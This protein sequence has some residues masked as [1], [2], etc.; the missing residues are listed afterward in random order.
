MVTDKSVTNASK[1]KIIRKHAYRVEFVGANTSAQMIPEK[2]LQTFNNYFIGNDSSKWASNVKIYHV[3][4]YK[5]IY[6][7]IDI[8]YYSEGSA[9]KYDVIV[10]PGGDPSKLY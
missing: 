6:P 4:A 8:R 3:V 10:H 1:N 2:P 5:N 9:L 7:N